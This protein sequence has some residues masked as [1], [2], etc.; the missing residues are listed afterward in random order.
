MDLDG[1]DLY[2]FTI[3][4]GLWLKDRQPPVVGEVRDISWECGIFTSTGVFERSIKRLVNTGWLA[5]REVTTKRK[6]KVHRYV[7][8]LRGFAEYAYFVDDMW[9]NYV[10]DML[11][12]EMREPPRDDCLDKYVDVVAVKALGGALRVLLEAAAVPAIRLSPKLQELVQAVHEGRGIDEVSQELLD[13]AQVE[14]PTLTCLLV[15]YHLQVATNRM[16]VM[17]ARYAYNSGAVTELNDALKTALEAQD[18]LAR[19]CTRIGVRGFDQLTENNT[20]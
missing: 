19:F 20:E 9:S 17:G 14:L 7:P 10:I 6:Q 5:V 11:R 2:T 3:I 15:H 16:A 18:K 4:A 13:L 12:G 1:R 8:T